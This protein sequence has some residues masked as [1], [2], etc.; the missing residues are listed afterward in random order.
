M[1]LPLLFQLFPPS[2]AAADTDLAPPPLPTNTT[3][4]TTGTA[5]GTS[6]A[7]YSTTSASFRASS[8]ASSPSAASCGGRRCEV[9]FR[10]VEGVCHHL[11]RR[12]WPSQ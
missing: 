3:T 11:R 10:K 6:N 7:A 1:Q 4:S 12:Q 8:R 9:L 2:A 5:S